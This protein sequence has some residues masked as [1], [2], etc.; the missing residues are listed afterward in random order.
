M[1]TPRTAP[2]S[3]LPDI[4][5]T[6][7]EIGCH[8][9]FANLQR[10][11]IERSAEAA[12]L[13]PCGGDVRQDRGGRRRARPQWLR[14]NSD[15]AP[16]ILE[17]STPLEVAS[18]ARA[19]PEHSIMDLVFSS[20][21]DLAAAIATR[22][23]SAV[24]ALDAHLAQI[25]SAQRGGQRRHLA[26]PGRRPRARQEGGRCPSA[27]RGARAAAWRAVHAE[28]HARDGW[29]EDHGRLPA[30]RRLCRQGRT[31]RSLPG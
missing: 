15:Q 22:K 16:P 11:K 4:S 29:H 10:C 2:P 5:P 31:A 24:E 26:R 17:C 14:R 30:L 21:V 8:D 28:G 18:R 6:G 23:I 1:R 20:T 19:K 25:D 7:G 9:A 3:V 12:N 27:R 13:P